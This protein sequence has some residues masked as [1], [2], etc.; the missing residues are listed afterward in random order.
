[1]N[2]AMSRARGPRCSQRGITLVELLIAMTIMAVL[3]TMIIMVWIALQ[4][5]YAYSVNSADARGTAR[6]AMSRMRMEIRDAMSDP[7]SGVGPIVVAANDHI[8]IMTA[9][10]DVGGDVEQV[11]Y[12]YRPTSATTGNITR[13]RGSGEELVLA[14]DIVNVGASVPLFR[15]SY[16]DTGGTIVTATSVSAGNT[17]RVLT[18]QIHILADTNPGHSPTFMDLIST[19]QP[20]NQRQF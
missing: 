18:V 14:S 6:D 17:P 8:R 10:N 16:V 7:V 11:D 12:W 19:V 13:Q 15:Y 2:H 20:R 9:F 5:S 3:T 1:M 4:G